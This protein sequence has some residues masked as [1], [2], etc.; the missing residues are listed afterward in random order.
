MMN[1][2]KYFLLSKI[3]IER[4]QIYVYIYIYIYICLYKY[5]HVWLHVTKTFAD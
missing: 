5:R 2:I 3:K 4:I 1:L